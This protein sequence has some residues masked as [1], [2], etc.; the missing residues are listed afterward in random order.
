MVLDSIVYNGA[1]EKDGAINASQKVFLQR[2]V[3]MLLSRTNFQDF[4]LEVCGEALGY[5]S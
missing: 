1:D 2:R 3:I 5:L 4:L